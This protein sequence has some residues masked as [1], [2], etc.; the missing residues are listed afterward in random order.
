M[1]V[2]LLPPTLGESHLQPGDTQAPPELS[3]CGLGWGAPREAATLQSCPPRLQPELRS[4]L[5][6]QEIQGQSTP[7]RGLCG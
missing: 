1:S 7:L 2:S 5:G 6:Q 4:L 3:P